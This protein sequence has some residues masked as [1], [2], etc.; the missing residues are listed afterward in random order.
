MTLSQIETVRAKAIDQLGHN[1]MRKIHIKSS[2]AKKPHKNA[3]TKRFKNWKWEDWD[4][5]C[6]I[7]SENGHST[8]KIFNDIFSF[9]G[10]S[11]GEVI[12]LWNNKDTI[13]DQMIH[14]LEK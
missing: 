2:I 9:N 6:Q 13:Y 14:D 8:G 5:F 4:F 12:E 1:A 7:F 3:L 10:K 11:L